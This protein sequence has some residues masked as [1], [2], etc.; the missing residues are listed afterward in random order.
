MRELDKQR[1]G[2]KIREVRK[3]RKMTQK[4]LAEKSG[5]SVPALGSYELGDR[6]PKEEARK[7]LAGALNIRT[8]AFETCGISNEAQFIHI[9]FNLEKWFKIECNKNGVPVVSVRSIGK[10]SNALSDWYEKRV[11][12]ERGEIKQEEYED[13]K[14]A[15][16]PTV[17]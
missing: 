15:Y 16:D 12:L 5:I 7:A 8:E 2:T 1:I 9:L 11:A 10:V 14:D 4:E 13:W 3:R 6:Y 17:I